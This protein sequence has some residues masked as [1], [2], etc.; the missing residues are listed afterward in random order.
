MCMEA[1]I[2]EQ[3]SRPHACVAVKKGEEGS[4]PRTLSLLTTLMVVWKL[5]SGVRVVFMCWG[6]SVFL[7][8]TICCCC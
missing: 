3:V 6:G 4:G 7:T 5:P 8:N 2:K 1:G